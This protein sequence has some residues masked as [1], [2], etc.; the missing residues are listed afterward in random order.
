MSK[1][2]APILTQPLTSGEQ[3]AVMRCKVRCAVS[4]LRKGLGA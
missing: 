1:I 3:T 2:T 4:A